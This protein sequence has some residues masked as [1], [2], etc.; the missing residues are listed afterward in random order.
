MPDCAKI[1]SLKKNT[2]QISCFI[3][4]IILL[5]AGCC[6]HEPWFDE[7]HAW[8]IAKDA[9]W[10]EILFFL[11]HFEGHPPFY[12]LLLALPAKLGIAWPWGMRLGNIFS[13]A[14]AYLL[15]FKSPFPRWVRL[16]LPFT[17]F[18]FYQ[19]SVI[20][21][22]YSI[23]MF[24]LFA[25]AYYF[26]QKDTRPL[27]FTGLLAAL[28]ACHLFG[29]T[30]AGGI[31]AAWLWDIKANQPW[32]IFLRGFRTDKR[33]HALLWLLLWALLLATL[34]YPIIDIGYF[35]AHAKSNAWMRLFYLLFLAPADTLITNVLSAV[36][37]SKMQ[38]S[39]VQCISACLVSSIMWILLWTGLPRKK[40]LYLLLPYGFT[41]TIMV[42]YCCRYHIGFLLLLFIWY[43]WISLPSKTYPAITRRPLF[44]QITRLLL[45]LGIFISLAWTVCAFVWDVKYPVVSGAEFASFMKEHGLWDKRVLANWFQREKFPQEENL[46][47]LAFSQPIAFYLGKN[48]FSNFEFP[49]NTSYYTSALLSPG[50]NSFYFQYWR[51]QGKP[52]ILAG[53]VPLHRIFTDEQAPILDYVLV[54]QMLEYDIWKF[55]PP[56]PTPLNIYV[57][58]D[59]LEKHHLHEIKGI[60]LFS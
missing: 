38:L 54:Y 7:L 32:K 60:P 43:V 52:D 27:L 8:L 9:P 13:I 3:L 45:I 12:H 58:K 16:T 33:L 21:R 23:L 57:R 1:L 31:A 50:T 35:S 10:G 17:F 29:I 41:I 53:D 4:F 44:Q 2:P 24:V 48:I 40:I 37:L 22:P 51:K 42:F 55:D 30:I 56:C 18:L 6:I 20:S 25:L 34:M 49:P 36:Y 11:P 26:P 19:F 28:C 15:I 59:L 47:R 46:T 39:S 14:A 5:I